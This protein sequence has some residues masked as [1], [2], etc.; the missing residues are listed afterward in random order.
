MINVL[1]PKST[2]SLPGYFVLPSQSTTVGSVVVPAP[3]LLVVVLAPPLLV[4]VLA[5]PLL[6]VV[7]APPLLVVVPC[8][9]VFG[10]VVVSFCPPPPHA[11]ANATTPAS[12][13]TAK[14]S[15]II[16]F[17]DIISFIKFFIAQINS[18]Y[19]FLPIERLLYFIILLLFCQ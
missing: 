15:V 13:T 1:P 7:L 5:P 8:V 10:V 12:I 9:V 17:I 18:R 19:L 3:P 4:V 16:L 2:S 14:R 6:V 11:T